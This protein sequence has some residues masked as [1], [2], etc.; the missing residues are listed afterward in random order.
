MTGFKSPIRMLR[1]F[2]STSFVLLVLDSLV[3]HIELLN[4]E[5]AIS[6]YSLLL[7][8]LQAWQV[9]LLLVVHA[10]VW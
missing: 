1:I 10:A 7:H 9:A 3:V 2:I 5:H 8:I 4:S 6:S